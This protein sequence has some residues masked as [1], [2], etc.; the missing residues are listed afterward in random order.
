ATIASGTTIQG[1]FIGT[2]ANGKAALGNNSNG[3]YS[4]GNGGDTIGGTA[5]GARNV[6]AA[7][8]NNAGI[9]VSP[10]TSTA[11]TIQGNLIGTDVTGTIALGNF[12]GIWINFGGSQGH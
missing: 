11:S 8:Q 10:G 5:S 7:T 4:G 12:F 2:T 1:N 9:F 6:I 3:V